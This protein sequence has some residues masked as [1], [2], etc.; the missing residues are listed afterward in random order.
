MRQAGL[1]LGPDVGWMDEPGAPQTAV[2]PGEL[3]RGQHPQCSSSAGPRCS[4]SNKHTGNV[5]EIF[6]VY[7]LKFSPDQSDF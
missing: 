7:L 5:L 1:P 6:H 4:F 3:L 2:T